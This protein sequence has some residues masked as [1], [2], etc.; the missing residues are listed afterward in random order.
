MEIV[1]YR[2][3]QCEGSTHSSVRFLCT[4]PSP[5]ETAS[6]DSPFQDYA[7]NGTDSDSVPVVSRG[8]EVAGFQLAAFL[9]SQHG[10]HRHH[11]QGELK[12]GEKD[13]LLGCQFGLS[14][15]AEGEKSDGA[16]T[17]SQPPRELLIERLGGTLTEKRH[18]LGL[19]RGVFP[20]ERGG[21]VYRKAT[22]NA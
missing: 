1:C 21:F 5:S 8:R 12:A 3:P 16:I 14:A 17:R 9:P 20:V 6:L 11:H 13:R 7:S 2:H 18:S 10:R 22:F 15:G 19:A 4:S